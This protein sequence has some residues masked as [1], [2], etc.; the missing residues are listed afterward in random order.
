[1]LFNGVIIE[2]G[3]VEEFKNSKNPI[4]QAFIEGNSEVYEKMADGI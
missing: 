3:T 2:F 1:M 4:V